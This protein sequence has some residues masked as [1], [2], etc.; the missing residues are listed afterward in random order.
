MRINSNLSFCKE[1]LCADVRKRVALINRLANHIPRGRPLNMVSKA[2]VLGKIHADAPVVTNPRLYDADPPDASAEKLQVSLNN[3]ARTL[4]GK[5]REDRIPVSTLLSK[6][7]IDSYNRMVVARSG[8]E[9]WKA[10]SDD[11]PL[12]EA[13]HVPPAS[14][15]TRAA[16]AGLLKVP[17][18]SKF[19]SLARSAPRI[20]NAC[21][22]IRSATTEAAA[23]AA[24]Y[25]FARNC[26]L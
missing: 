20:W 25:K 26:P 22:G 11:S 13:L 3:M 19:S 17:A 23:R 2:L 14:T 9:A 21:E 18:P 6:C 24:A 8:L 10:A 5:K 4:L 1:A 12:H 7:N 15:T 16:T